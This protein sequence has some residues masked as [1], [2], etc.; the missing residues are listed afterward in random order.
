MGWEL[1]GIPT[2]LLALVSEYNNI[3]QNPGLAPQSNLPGEEVGNLG[4]HLEAA[5][6]LLFV[7]ELE[8][9]G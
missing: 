3:G 2:G 7:A 6:I 8:Q 9:A 1:S 4:L 5:K